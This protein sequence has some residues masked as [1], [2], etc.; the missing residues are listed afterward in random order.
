[1][2]YINA[3]SGDPRFK[4]GAKVLFPLLV[5]LG[6]PGEATLRYKSGTIREIKVI[7]SDDYGS[8]YPIGTLVYMIGCED[9]MT[10]KLGCELILDHPNM[11]TKLRNKILNIYKKVLK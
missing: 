11:S 5:K 3:N 2:K 9:F 10:P 8:E 1:M 6:K 7:E 4:V